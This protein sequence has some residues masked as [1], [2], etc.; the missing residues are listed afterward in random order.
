M[1]DQY[2]KESLDHIKSF[3]TSTKYATDLNSGIEIE[4]FPQVHTPYRRICCNANL[5]KASGFLI[6]EMQQE[7]R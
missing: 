2:I 1:Q 3:Q 6:F 5:K 7:Y 4:L